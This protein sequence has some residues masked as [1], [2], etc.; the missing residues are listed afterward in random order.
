MPYLEHLYCDECKHPFNL[1]VDFQGTIEAYQRDE[2]PNAAINS[3]TLVWD[4]LIYSCAKCNK[5]YKFTFRDVE[6]RVREHI[7][8]MGAMYKEYIEELAEYNDAEEKRLSGEFFKKKDTEVKKK[9]S[10]R[11]SR[12]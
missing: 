10:A 1:D 12:D 3:P 8:N 2:R 7:S 5:K 6:Q 4:Y 9:I 11:Y